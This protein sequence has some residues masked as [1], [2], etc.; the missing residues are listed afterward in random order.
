LEISGLQIETLKEV[1]FGPKKE[2]VL[3]KNGGPTEIILRFFLCFSDFSGFFPSQAVA[4]QRQAAIPLLPKKSCLKTYRRFFVRSR[5]CHNRPMNDEKF[6]GQWA[7]R[8]PRHRDS[9]ANVGSK[10]PEF[11]RP[12]A[13]IQTRID[14]AAKCNSALP[15]CSQYKPV[16]VSTSEYQKMKNVFAPIFLPFRARAGRPL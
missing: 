3:Q 4:F 14:P 12:P 5:M 11:T 13:A 1:R 8:I 6:N 7:G 16:Q 2:A 15:N 9:A 10:G